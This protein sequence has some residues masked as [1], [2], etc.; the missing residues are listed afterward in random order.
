MIVLGVILLI[1]GLLFGLSILTYIGIILIVVGAV[2]WIL[3]STGRAVGGR[4]R[5][6]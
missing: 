6:Y 4:A 2:F 1:L 5:W 3:G